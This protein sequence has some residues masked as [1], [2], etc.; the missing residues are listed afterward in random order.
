M[1]GPKSTSSL[2]EPGLASRLDAAGAAAAL[3]DD[4]QRIVDAARETLRQAG[5]A[6]QAVQGLFFTGGSTG[7]ASLVDRIGAVLPAAT[8]VRGDR[9]ASVV[10][11]L[12]LHAAR[13]F[14]AADR[15]R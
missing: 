11:G 9:F 3:N 12:G 4:R 5:L 1:V 13:L 8:V 7:L 2:I 14:G 6:P 15:P 10:M